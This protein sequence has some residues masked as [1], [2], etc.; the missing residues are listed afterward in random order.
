M[1]CSSPRLLLLL[2]ERR[3]CRPLL[4]AASLFLKHNLLALPLASAAVADLAGLIAPRF[5][6]PALD[7]GCGAGAA[8]RLP[9]SFRL[10]P[11]G[12]SSPRRGLDSL[13]NVV[14]AGTHLWW[15]AAAPGGRHRH[16]ARPR[17]PALPGSMAP[18]RWLL[19]LGFAGGD[20]VDANVFFD[21][22]IALAL[23]LGLA[24]DRGRWPELAAASR[25]AADPV[26]GRQLSRQQF[27]LHPRLP[28]ASRRAT[29]LF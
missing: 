10:Q 8:H 2:R 24:M 16:L 28:R 19:G 15:A 4:F 11:A 29:S 9:A 17:Q 23:T 13:A 14:A 3:S 6:C 5:S 22:A 18:S 26:P 7:G 12:R 20:G 1:P 21:L 25:P 27:L